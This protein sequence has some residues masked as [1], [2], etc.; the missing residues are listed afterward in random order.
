M[1]ARGDRR[2]GAVI[3]R[4]WQLGAKFDTWREHFVWDKWAQALAEHKLSADRYAR[5][6]IPLNETLPW[7]HLSSGIHRA[8]L[9]EEYNCSLTATPRGDCR[10]NCFNCGIRAAFDL[11]ECPA[12]A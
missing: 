12:T 3:H 4:A 7:A 11:T 10:E 6:V 1:L 8:Y 2:L 9:E 5:R